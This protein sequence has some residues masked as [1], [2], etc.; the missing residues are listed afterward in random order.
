MML[1]VLVCSIMPKE[2]FCDDHGEPAHH[3]CTLICH[4]SLNVIDTALSWE[5]KNVFLIPTLVYSFSYQNPFL[6]HFKR[7]PIVL[8]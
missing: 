5:E 4:T 3:H 1:L 8:S 2:A 7:P 6:T